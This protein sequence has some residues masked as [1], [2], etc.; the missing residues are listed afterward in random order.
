[1]DWVWVVPAGSDIVTFPASHDRI[2]DRFSIAKHS[3]RPAR[4]SRFA[5]NEYR[6]RGERRASPSPRDARNGVE[7]FLDGVAAGVAGG[8]GRGC[9]GYRGCVRRGGRRRR[10]RPARLWELELL[11][12]AADG[13]LAAALVLVNDQVLRLRDA[14]LVAHR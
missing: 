5:A 2:S 4:S 1:M 14:P 6:G 7:F 11:A 9:R 8:G 13:D 3:V 10:D 12:V